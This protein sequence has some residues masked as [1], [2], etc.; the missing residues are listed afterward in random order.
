MFSSQ[1]V[2]TSPSWFDDSAV[3]PHLDPTFSVTVGHSLSMLMILAMLVD[4]W[5]CSVS[6]LEFLSLDQTEISIQLL[7]GFPWIF[8]RTIVVPRGWSLTTLVIPLKPPAG[9]HFWLLV[10]WSIL[11]Y[12]VVSWYS[13]FMIFNT[14]KEMLSYLYFAECAESRSLTK[15]HLVQSYLN[16]PSLPSNPIYKL[17]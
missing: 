8:I 15:K 17:L 9:W 14:N 13:C 7:D 2:L 3:A 1:L 11:N 16:H 12:Y 5:K 4:R 10:K 6:W